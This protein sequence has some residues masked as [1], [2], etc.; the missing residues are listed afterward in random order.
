MALL[1]GNNGYLNHPNL[2]APMVDVFELSV[3]LRRLGF[4]VI[5]LID[6][7]REE[8]LISVKQF[9]QL[10]DKGVYGEFVERV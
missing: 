9:L 4:C 3:L 5:S 6:L 10:L 2:L 8:M 7:T 1:I